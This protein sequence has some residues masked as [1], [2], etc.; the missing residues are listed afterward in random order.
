MSDEKQFSSVIE[1]NEQEEKLHDEVAAV[2]SAA[3]EMLLKMD[4]PFIIL[5]P[6]SRGGLAVLSNMNPDYIQLTLARGFLNSQDTPAS[7]RET[8]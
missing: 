1:G 7:R 2:Y 4:V 5:A 8:S 3:S 6:V